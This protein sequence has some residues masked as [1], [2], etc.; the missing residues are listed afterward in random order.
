MRTR[1]R[2]SRP[3]DFSLTSCGSPELCTDASTAASDE[4]A[5]REAR[6]VD[7]YAAPPVSDAVVL[8]VPHR[9]YVEMGWS[10]ICP[11]LNSDRGIVADI[12]RTLDVERC[13]NG[14]KL[15]RL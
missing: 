12:K 5:R 6:G 7:L 15:W 4:A 10:G 11:L 9:A 2:T 8:A 3:T 13:P 14:I 1:S